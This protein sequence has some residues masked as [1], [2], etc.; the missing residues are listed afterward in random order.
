MNTVSIYVKDA[1]DKS[2]KVYKLCHLETE[3]NVTL[4]EAYGAGQDFLDKVVDDPEGKTDYY[5]CK[6]GFSDGHSYEYD[7]KDRDVYLDEYLKWANK[8]AA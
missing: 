8:A 4:E 6:L 5:I 3:E 2:G 7:R 1:K